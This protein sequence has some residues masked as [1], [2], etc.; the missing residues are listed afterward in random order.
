LGSA[1][2]S[3]NATDD[4]QRVDAA[5]V[6]KPAHFDDVDAALAALD[7]GNPAMGHFQADGEFALS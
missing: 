1:P 3:D 2:A 7:L 6:E 5:R 4:I